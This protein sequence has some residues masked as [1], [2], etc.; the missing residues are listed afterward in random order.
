MNRTLSKLKLN[1]EFSA[2]KK[3]S[4][5]LLVAVLLVVPAF[6]QQAEKQ[7]EIQFTT[8]KEL[9]I[10]SVK[11]QNRSSTCW[12]FSGLAFLESELLRMNKGEFDL[13]EMFVVHHNFTDKAEKFVRLHG[14][15]SFGPGGSFYDVIYAFKQYGA[16]PQEAMNGL[17]YGE[18]LPVHNEI[19]N[20]A[21]AYVDAV[22]K[23]GNGKLS[24]VWMKGY[25]G[26]IDA[27]LGAIPEKFSYNGKEYTPKTFAD[28]L[29]LNADDYVS[30]TSYT[31]H[32]FYTSFALEI[33]DNWRWAESYNLPLDELMSVFDNAI[34]NGYTIAWGADV[35]EKGFSRNG[36][37][38]VPDVNMSELSGSDQAKWL[39]L[40]SRERDNEITRL[41]MKPGV[42]EKPVTQEM[43]QQAYDNYET[44]DD[45][46][47]Q[48]YGIANDQ[49]G[50]KFYMVK[51]SWGTNN[52]YKGTWYVSE[53]FAKY[54]TMNIIVHKNALPAAIKQKLGIK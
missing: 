20:I 18:D 4:I 29:G 47:M 31:H 6:A 30:L 1:C 45:H 11:N 34:N 43:R 42:Y 39:G 36:V 9:K 13:A 14:E 32:P 49:T 35:S 7:E 37:A 3:G 26:I 12:S 16:V 10:T 51:N 44:T 40:S 50:K 21:K 25:T 52:P 41:A 54:K 27:Y 38:T 8:V 5:L 2:A 22:I 15:G 53:A 46:G 19:D 23:N 48:I 17:N 24:P 33:Q 28:M